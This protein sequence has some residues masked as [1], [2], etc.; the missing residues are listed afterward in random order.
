MTSI[1]TTRNNRPP[2]ISTA[3]NPIAGAT[4]PPGTPVI[5]SL[6]VD[7]T[8]I[9]G[10]AIDI[11]TASLVGIASGAG[12]AGRNVFVQYA[13]PLALTIEQWD[14][15]IAGDSN[16]GLV[17]GMPY[18]LAA[19]NTAGA[20]GKITLRPSLVFEDQVIMQIGVALSPTEMLILLGLPLP[21]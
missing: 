7:G 2:P 15:V 14:A 18:F 16:G 3:Y 21:T 5:Q 20:E 17:R 8:V 4:F 19:T 12:F 13:G 11:G 10:N 9:P 6:V 1:T